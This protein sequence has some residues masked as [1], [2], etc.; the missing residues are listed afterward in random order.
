MNKNKLIK[1]VDLKTWAKLKKLA[2][3]YNLPIAEMLKLLIE[4]F[5]NETKT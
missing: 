1:N 5:K 4:R 2:I 3:D